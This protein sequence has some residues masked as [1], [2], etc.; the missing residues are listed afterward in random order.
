MYVPQGYVTDFASVPRPFRWLVP[1]SGKYNQAAVVHDYIYTNL[2]RT[3]TKDQADQ[4]FFDA[5][6]EL[7]VVRWKRKLMYFAVRIGGRGNW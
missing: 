5:M 3:L 4:I 6:Q 7:G 1:K 2:Y